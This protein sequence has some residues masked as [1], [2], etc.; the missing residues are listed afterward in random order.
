MRQLIKRLLL[1]PNSFDPDAATYIAAAGITNAAHRNAINTYI[2]GLKNA[3]LW[4]NITAAYIAWNSATTAATNL[5]GN[6]LNGTIVGSPTIGSSG[7]ASSASSY[8]KTG[9]IPSTDLTLN[10]HSIG[11]Y[12]K[13]TGGNNNVIV[14]SQNAGTTQRITLVAGAIT[15]AGIEYVDC[16]YTG[17]L[18]KTDIEGKAT[19]FLLG[20]RTA[21]GASTMYRN[22]TSIITGTQTGSMPTMEL[23]FDGN[24]I[25][26]NANPTPQGSTS[27]QYGYFHVGKHFDSTQA[28]NYHTLITTLL[29]S[30]SVI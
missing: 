12:L 11:V 10:D 13:G 6:T 28:S 1:T 21:G 9:I 19:A 4:N 18:L 5:K 24:N 30:L 16:N 2:V 25:S 7:Y 27:R 29:T 23:V 14:G 26:G 8:F 15:T 20:T 3:G 22:G 17:R